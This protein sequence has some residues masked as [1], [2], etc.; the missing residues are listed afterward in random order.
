MIPLL[1][2]K[3]QYKGIA[4]EINKAIFEVLSSGEY[5]LGHFVSDFEEKMAE[6]CNIK[7]AIGCASGTDA[8]L[9]SLDAY[10]IKKGDEVIT[11]P[12]TF[13]STASVIWRLSAKPVFCDINP[14]TY[15]INPN[16][17]EDLITEKTKG[18]IVVHL[19]GQPAEL[20]PIL[21]IAN[22]YNLFVIED[23]AQ[24]LG[25]LYKRKKI[26]TFGDC[27]CFSF[28]PTKNLGCYGDGGMIITDNLEIA[29]KIKILRVHG[30]K[31]KYHHL[32]VGYNSRLDAIQAVC[33]S[34]KLKYIDEWN[35]KRREKANIYNE[36]LSSC[37]EVT[38]PFINDDSSHVFNQYVIRAKKRNELKEY[39]KNNGIQTRVYYPLPLHLQ[40]CF[41]GLGYKKGDFP[42]SEKASAET[43][44]LPIY[45]ELKKE[46]QEIVASKIK[47]FYER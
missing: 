6:Y 38:L 9:L 28:F 45:P 46:E 8:L 41:K 24:S 27:G 21:E 11:T 4:D 32:I 2:L 20:E 37:T 14:L 16:L 47:E 31:P 22:K 18:I 35:K 33:L 29:E 42:E 39:L 44:A 23:A 10:G 15:N 43:L 30:A 19:F 1:D 17:I 26:G 36:L 12:Y 25:A 5:I 13:F 7:F 34:L 3:I 40:E